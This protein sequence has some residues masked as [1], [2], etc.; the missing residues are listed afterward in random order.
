MLR[1]PNHIP[2]WTSVQCC[3]CYELHAMEPDYPRDIKAFFFNLCPYRL[4]SP[5]DLLRLIPAVLLVWGNS[6][7]RK[8]D[9]IQQVWLMPKST[10]SCPWSYLT[11]PSSAHCSLRSAPVTNMLVMVDVASVAL[12]WQQG[13]EESWNS[14]WA[15]TPDLALAP[16]FLNWTKTHA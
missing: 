15:T 7:A 13:P 6:I 9:K 2:C 10:P 12:W 5:M 11:L 3:Q 14:C 8:G 1:C 16:L 4:S